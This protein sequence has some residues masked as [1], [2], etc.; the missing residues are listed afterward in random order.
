[1]TA[2][3]GS[4]AGASA[5][6][7]AGKR[8]ARGRPGAR[9][10]SSRSKARGKRESPRSTL[11]REIAFSA[12]GCL[13]VLVGVGLIGLCGGIW[14]A[15]RLA[16]NV[17]KEISAHDYAGPRQRIERYER[18]F[19]SLDSSVYSVEQGQ[20]NIDQDA[21]QSVSWVVTLRGS[22]ERRRFQW[23]HDLEAQTVRPRTN[24]ALCLDVEMGI[25]TEKEAEDYKGLESDAEKYNPDD[26]MVRAIVKSN[27]SISPQDLSGGWNTPEEEPV[28]APLISPEEGVERHT[29]RKK[30]EEEEQEGENGEDEPPVP[31]DAT[32]VIGTGDEH[33]ET[34]D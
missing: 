23:E 28:G 11:G 10:G 12:L 32:D 20:R 26:P 18:F 6:S 24:P 4:G 25:M 30:Q 33:G 3:S 13:W 2:R 27:Y 14:Y 15:S 8:A 34:G 21:N 5:Q 1:M 29:G 22:E 9:R 31:Q 17:L 16:V 7:Q 19:Q